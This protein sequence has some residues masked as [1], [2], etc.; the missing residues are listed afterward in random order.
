[1]TKEQKREYDRKHYLLNQERKKKYAKEYHF[2]NREKLLEGIAVRSKKRYLNNKG[3]IKEYYKVYSP[4]YRNKNREKINVYRRGHFL[5]RKKEDLL[6]K[7]Q[8]QIRGRIC[9]Y[10]QNLRV[11]KYSNTIKLLGADYLTVMSHIESN[12]REGMS[13]D[14]VGKEIHIDHI[15]PLSSAKTKEELLKLF[16]YKNLQPLWAMDNIRK[17]AKIEN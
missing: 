6:F 17:G 8:T 9:R 16:H 4:I 12:F 2:A 7:V 3:K 15:I 11:G 5:R 13:W 14:K 1:M 10:F